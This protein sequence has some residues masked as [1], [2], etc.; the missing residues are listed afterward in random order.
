MMCLNLCDLCEKIL[1]LDFCESMV[2]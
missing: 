1:M 2:Y